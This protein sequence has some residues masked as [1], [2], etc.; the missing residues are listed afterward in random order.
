MNIPA[1]HEKNVFGSFDGNIKK[2][3][4]TLHVT[5]I[6]RDSQVKII[7]SDVAAK[8]ARSVFEQLIE[9]SKRGN[10]ITVSRKSSASRSSLEVKPNLLA[11]PPDSSHFP[12][13]EDLAL[14]AL[15]Y[16]FLKIK[17]AEAYGTAIHERYV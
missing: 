9:L 7:G 15:V 8:R 2:I 6:A 14:L 3:E 12:L 1:E 16:R 13:P 17:E 4:R 10:T 5:V 11:S